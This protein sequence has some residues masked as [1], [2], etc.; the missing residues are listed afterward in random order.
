MKSVNV[1]LDDELHARLKAAAE[2][3]HRSLQQQITWLL[4]TSV[5]DDPRVVLVQ[6]R[7]Q[8]ILKETK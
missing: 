4:E 8:A 1:R 5:D 6:Q 3:D 2:R 7:A